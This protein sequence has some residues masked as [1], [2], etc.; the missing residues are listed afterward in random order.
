[1]LVQSQ[2]ISNRTKEMKCREMALKYPSGLKA[3]YRSQWIPRPNMFYN[4]G[5][6]MMAVLFLMMAVLWWFAE[7]TRR[8]LPSLIW[9]IWGVLTLTLWI[10]GRQWTRKH[11]DEQTE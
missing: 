9:A 7:T 11:A 6:L 5:S 4:D 8:I 10:Y 3:W 1:M 2:R